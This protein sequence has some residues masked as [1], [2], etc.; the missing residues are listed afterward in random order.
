MSGIR[1][2]LYDIEAIYIVPGL[3]ASIL[4][5]SWI[6]NGLRPAIPADLMTPL[7]VIIDLHRQHHSLVE[8][9][10][11]PMHALLNKTSMQG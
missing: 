10:R 9:S 5:C 11:E 8:L 6:V 4:G 3:L 7:F 2:V 1:E